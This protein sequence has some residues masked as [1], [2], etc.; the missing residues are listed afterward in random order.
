[1]ADIE[2]KTLGESHREAFADAG[3]GPFR[4]RSAMIGF[5]LSFLSLST[6]A[7]LAAANG[8]QP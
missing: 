5:G 8:P 4:G 6:A 7:D 3:I 1:V 2:T